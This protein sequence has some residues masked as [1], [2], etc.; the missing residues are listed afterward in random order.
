[1]RRPVWLAGTGLLALAIPFQLVA[2]FL[3]PLT[4]IQPLGAVALVLSTLMDARA[5]HRRPS[6][7]LLGAVGLSVAGIGVFVGVAAA[8]TASRPVQS[9]QLLTMLVVLAVVLVIAAPVVLLLRTRLP[10]IALVLGAGVLFGFV[11]SL[12]KVVLDRLHTIWTIGSGFTSA[13][14][15]TLACLVGMGLSGILGAV[16]V[17]T[18]YASGPASLVVAG[19]TVVDPVVGVTLGV[20][21]LGEAAQAPIWA[22]FVFVLTG[23][24]AVAGVVLLARHRPAN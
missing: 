2:L 7:S 8:T 6:R 22:P 5:R 10:R 18:A 16:L 1:M 23:A 3:A 19:L 17:Q 15:W 9:T 11:G 20:V 4:V 14:W 12:T 24:T 21:V 13:D